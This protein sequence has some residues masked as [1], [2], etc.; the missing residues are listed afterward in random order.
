[1]GR[2]VVGRRMGAGG[3]AGR[4][5]V[6]QGALAGPRRGRCAPT[7]PH[8]LACSSTSLT[9]PSPHHPA[10]CRALL[11]SPSSTQCLETW[12]TPTT[13]SPVPASCC[14]PAG[15]WA[16]GMWREM[17]QGQAALGGR[18]SSFPCARAAARR[19]PAPT[20]CPSL[21]C[22]FLP[23]PCSYLVISHP[24]GRP[25]HE[26]FRAREPQLVP[27]ELPQVC[28]GVCWQMVGVGR[29]G[30]TALGPAS[31]GWPT[32]AC[33]CTCACACAH[34]ACPAACQ[35]CHRPPLHSAAR[36]AGVVAS[37][38]AAAGGQ[39]LG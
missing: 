8:A 25:W 9:A 36:G 35:T 5:E 16:G 23:A 33:A 29:G 27:H 2:W 18:A 26:A 38:P 14:A 10:T 30:A 11:M 4:A 12:P 19:C 22:P 7:M 34:A 32:G 1:V 20:S 6:R 13:P 24:L 37:R 31:A 15:A 28:L 17:L 21:Y 39:L 3:D